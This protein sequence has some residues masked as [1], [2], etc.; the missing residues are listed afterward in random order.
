MRSANKIA[1]LL[2]LFFIPALSFSESDVVAFFRRI[3]GV[4]DYYIEFKIKFH[5]YDK[6]REKFTD[7]SLAFTVGVRDLR[8]FYIRV[9]G[10]KIVEG[11]EFI[12]YSKE[13]KVYS[14]FSGRYYPDRVDLSDEVFTRVLKDIVDVI[15]S[16]I[17]IVRKVEGESGVYKFHL[18]SYFLLKRLGLEPVDVL[19]YFDGENLKKIRVDGGDGEFVDIE[20]SKFVV[21]RSEALRKIFSFR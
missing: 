21:G 12:Y 20:F 1:L 6:E 16:P 15:T 5:V 4:R 18:S 17:F 8:D 10:P 7:S 3:A 11:M 14:G 13:K 9:D 19:V 2:A